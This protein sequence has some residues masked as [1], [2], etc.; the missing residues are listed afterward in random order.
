MLGAVLLLGIIVSTIVSIMPSSLAWVL[1]L[2]WPIRV[3]Y[4]INSSHPHMGHHSPKVTSWK[5]LSCKV[6][7]PMILF[8]PSSFPSL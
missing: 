5:L 8:L 2:L 6:P 4:S 1:V 3:S 7:I